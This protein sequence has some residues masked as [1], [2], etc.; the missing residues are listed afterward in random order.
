MK[1][2]STT[3]SGATGFWVQPMAVWATGFAAM[4]GF[5]GIGLVDPILNSIAAGLRASPSQVSL[6][7]TSYF[8]VTSL[9][10][11]ITG[12][13]SSR[14]G[15]RN[16]LLL[17]LALIIVFSALAGTSDSVTELVLFRGGWG[18]GNALFVAT[19]LSV[20]VGAASGG[21]TVAILLYEAAL[22]LGLSLGPLLGA[23]LGNVSWRYPFFGTATL[24][25]I[26]FVAL[27]FL[28]EKQPPAARKT[29]I[30]E[31]LRALGHGGLAATALSAFCYN[32]GFF[33][34]L[35]FVPFVL[36]MSPYAIGFIFFGWGTALAVFSVLV[37]PHLQR[38]IGSVT[39]LIASL[40]LF[41]LDLLA[42]AFGSVP[43]I[44]AAVVLS[45]ALMGLNN[46]I[47]TEM[48]M[49]V[50]EVP[51][52]VASA[53]YN[54]VRWFAGIIAPFTAPKLAEHLGVQVPF[55]L[56]ALFAVLALSILYLARRRFARL[57]VARRPSKPQPAVGAGRP[58]LVALDASEA[59]LRVVERA[60]E[61][62]RELDAPVHVLHI[63]TLEMIDGEAAAGESET[64]AQAVV[65][66]ALASLR[67]QG[68]TTV[69]GA[70]QEHPAGR[71]GAAIVTRA[72]QLGA[73]L[74]VIGTRHH[75]DLG[76]VLHGSVSESVTCQARCA[77]LLVPT[78]GPAAAAADPSADPLPV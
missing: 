61:A 38:R 49:E 11:L 3:A 19:A 9:M 5:M 15:G 12:Y 30:T 39:V 64:A 31:P 57:D 44:V 50:S 1:T 56:A 48:A 20:I 77:I 33:T 73:Q 60:A 24:M 6:L 59:A 78:E 66:R 22:G 13:V 2:E 47:Y 71:A 45:G 41:A 53:G 18:L 7:F 62:A 51:R 4:V 72:G 28:L 74:I 29:G 10:M 32:Y 34:V 58:V 69:Q 70:W 75:R 36:G 54:F 46:T 37:A 65:A 14:I 76:H 21:S 68:L 40:L 43:V 63:R 26:G 55:V 42:I 52:A 67:A 27:F 17:G 35:A 16:T 25:A 23:V 8:A